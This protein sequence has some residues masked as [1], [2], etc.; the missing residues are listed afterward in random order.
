M[1]FLP[2]LSRQIQQATN[3]LYHRKRKWPIFSGRQQLPYPLRSP[4]AL[5]RIEQYLKQH[6][7]LT[8]YATREPLFVY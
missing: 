2:F 1:L 5:R 7:W 8:I 4:T 3:A 6:H